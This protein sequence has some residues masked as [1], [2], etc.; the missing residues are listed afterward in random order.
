MRTFILVALALCTAAGTLFAGTAQQPII[1]AFPCPGGSE[2]GY[3]LE[4][5][6]DRNGDGVMDTRSVRN[7][8]GK[9]DVDCWPT[10]CKKSALGGSNCPTTHHVFESVFD[11]ALGAYRW[12]LREFASKDDLTLI[13]LLERSGEQLRYTPQ[14]N[15]PLKS[16]SDR[17]SMNERPELKSLSAVRQT[18]A[19]S[20]QFNMSSND[21]VTVRLESLNGEVIYSTTMQAVEGANQITIPPITT[22]SQA[23]FIRVI[24]TREM[25]TAKVVY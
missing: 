15:A 11:P 5:T 9:W 13:G 4:I 17:V 18:G 7:C 23:G 12:T 20:V 1:I 6:E 16:S 2:F 19:I 10:S 22:A 14:C 24:G 3:G 8:N 21:N 25:M